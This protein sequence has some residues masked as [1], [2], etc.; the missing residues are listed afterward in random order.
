[1]LVLYGKRLNLNQETNNGPGV[2]KLKNW[3][4]HKLGIMKEPV[5]RN[6]RISGVSRDKNQSP[7]N[8]YESN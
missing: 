3:N 8:N 1:M 6:L 5:V 2:E 4:C 7:V